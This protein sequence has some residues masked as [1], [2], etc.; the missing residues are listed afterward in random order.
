M[1]LPKEWR[2]LQGNDLLNVTDIEG[3]KFVHADGFLGSNETFEGALEMALFSIDTHNTLQNSTSSEVE[4]D[5][6]FS[7]FEDDF[8]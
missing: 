7:L 1:Y 8:F 4:S 6:A 3:C 5:A 2:G